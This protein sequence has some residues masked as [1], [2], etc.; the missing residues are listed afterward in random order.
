[1]LVGND[2]ITIPTE[3]DVFP[4][5]RLRLSEPQARIEAEQIENVAGASCDLG[6]LNEGSKM[7]QILDGVNVGGGCSGASFRGAIPA[8]QGIAQGRNR[9]DFDLFQIHGQLEDR[10]DCIEIVTASGDR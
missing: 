4:M 8:A 2:I 6:C 7:G 5:Q 1:M 10:S 9:T 3:P